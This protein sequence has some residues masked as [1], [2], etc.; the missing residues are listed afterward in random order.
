MIKFKPWYLS[1]TIWASGISIS[2]ALA[3]LAGL[4]MGGIDQGAL[5]DQICRLFRRCQASWRFSGASARVRKSAE[6]GGTSSFMRRSATLLYT[7]SHDEK[8]PRLHRALRP[9]YRLRRP[10]FWPSG[11]CR[12]GQGGGGCSC[13]TV[14]VEVDCY[15]VGDQLA[16]QNGG[17][18]A[19]AVPVTQDGQAMC[20]IVLLIPGAEGERPRREE[21]LVPQ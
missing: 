8:A 1:K 19:K 5:T 12:A 17:T 9:H 21:I 16:Q 13:L 3:S 14:P 7:A 11:I 10:G 6:R 4:P 2:C 18:V 20:R 15:A